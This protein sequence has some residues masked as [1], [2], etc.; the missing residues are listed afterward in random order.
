MGILLILFQETGGKPCAL[1]G[2]GG[3]GG[4]GLLVNLFKGMGICNLTEF[5][6]YFGTYIICD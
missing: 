4:E 5:K 2:G 1:H 3:G 6:A